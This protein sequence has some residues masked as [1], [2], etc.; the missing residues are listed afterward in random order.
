MGPPCAWL[1]I[2]RWLV[3]QKARLLACEH[4]HVIFSIPRALHDL[5]L[6]NVAVLTPLLYASVRD[7]LLE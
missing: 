7:T 1:Q 3:T 4:D 6:A 5:W 2:E